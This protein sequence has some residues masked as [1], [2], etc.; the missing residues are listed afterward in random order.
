[1]ALRLR[2]GGASH[3][4]DLAI[5]GG[6]GLTL[7]DAVGEFIYPE[8]V[9][10]DAKDKEGLVACRASAVWRCFLCTVLLID[11]SVVH[12]WSHLANAVALAACAPRDGA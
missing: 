1:M 2:G 4:S 10:A 9:V 8:L 11:P 12:A 7:V 5:Y 6:A 3:I